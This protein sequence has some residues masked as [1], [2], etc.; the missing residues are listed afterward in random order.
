MRQTFMQRS[1]G[2]CD[3]A[4]LM[5]K[6]YTFGPM[7]DLPDASPFVMKVM[8]LLKLA[9]LDYVE[10]RGGYGKAPKGKLPFIEDNGVVIADSAFIRFHLEEQHGANFDGHLTAEQR[11]TG[12]AV[13]KMCEDHLIGIV[14]HIRWLDDANF[15]N[16]PARFFDRA[17]ALIRPFIKKMV[18]RK[19][20]K[21]LYVQGIG[22]HTDAERLRLGVQD[23]DALSTLLGDKPYF[24][25]DAP[26]G[27]DATVFAFVAGLLSPLS[28]SPLRDHALALPN[29]VAYRDR[30]TAQFFG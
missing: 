18:R 7:A 9:G 21:A 22:R 1:R 10:D 19:V 5:I 12:V 2:I 25:G 3:G 4:P 17:P 23:V 26:S 30:L 14:A 28:A 13:E 16:G 27:T 11:A 20:A 24:F 29:L 6:L 15:E 8:T